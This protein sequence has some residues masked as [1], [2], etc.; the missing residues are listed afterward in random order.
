MGGSPFGSGSPGRQERSSAATSAAPGGSAL[1]SSASVTAGPGGAR[2]G[3]GGCVCSSEACSCAS[4]G[5]GGS[6]CAYMAAVWR[7]ASTPGTLS[8]QPNGA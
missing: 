5:S 7:R 4:V 6:S 2:D 3:G 1:P 8:G